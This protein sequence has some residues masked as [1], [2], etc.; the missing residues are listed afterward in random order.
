M[1]NNP[2]P[3]ATCN[4][5]DFSDTEEQLAQSEHISHRGFDI[6]TCT[7]K[8]LPLYTLEQFEEMKPKTLDNLYLSKGVKKDLEFVELG[9]EFLGCTHLCDGNEEIHVFRDNNQK[10]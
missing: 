3:Y 7:G 10:E 6:G 4:K 5:F 1:N 2:R 9:Y 8:M